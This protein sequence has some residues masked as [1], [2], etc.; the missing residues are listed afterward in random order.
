MHEPSFSTHVV[1]ALLSLSWGTL[2]S[3]G[4]WPAV[5]GS[6]AQ[7]ERLNIIA[8]N[9]A[10]ADTNGFKRDQV[11][12]H[13][14]LSSA[15][16]AAMKEGIPHKAFTDKDFYKLDGRDQAYV[17]VEG[18]FTDHTQG[19][20]RVTGNPLDVSLE[21]KGFLEVLAPEGVRLSRQGTM[22]MNHEGTLVTNEGFPVLGPATKA[23]AAP[24]IEG[25]PRS[26]LMARTIKLDPGASTKVSITT[27]GKIFQGGQEI[28]ELSVVE[29]VDQNLLYKE[30]SSLFRNDDPANV[31]QDPR[32]TTVRQGIIETSNVNSISEM[33]EMLKAT[34]LF[35]ANEK[36]VKT[37]GDL[38]S[39]A[40]NDLGK[41]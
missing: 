31:S 30:G 7:N 13:T 23:G 8:N 28:G 1:R 20:A 34:R 37:Y 19:K 29:V 6:V 12:F 38:E 41:L 32:S 3:K 22:R 5:S 35:E 24:G 33:T 15:T 4:F 21:G 9:L 10:N 25:E 2:M 26:D 14:V 17:E 11:T 40:V 16:S 39:R 36:I 27:D 18:N